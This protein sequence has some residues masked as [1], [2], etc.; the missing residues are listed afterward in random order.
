M[1][2]QIARSLVR[3]SIAGLLATG[4]VRAT[5]MDQTAAAAAGHFAAAAHA[6]GLAASAADP[7]PFIQVAKTLILQPGQTGE[8]VATGF[9]PNGSIVKVTSSALSVVKESLTGNQYRAT[10]SASPNA[11]PLSAG[12]EVRTGN[13]V[14]RADHAVSI[15]GRFKGELTAA[16]GWK[17]RL[18]P[19]T[20]E[21]MSTDA[22]QFTAD[23]FK[24][25][26]PAPFKSVKASLN[27]SGATPENPRYTLQLDSSDSTLLGG[28]D[29]AKVSEELVA[30][31]QDLVKATS[32]AAQAKVQ[33]RMEKVQAK[34]DACAE[35]QAKATEAMLSDLAAYSK[36]A[37]AEQAA[38]GCSSAE[39]TI[40]ADGAVQ[41]RMRCGKD[42]G[43]QA[44]TGSLQRVMGK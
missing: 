6:A 21:G 15:G 18:T 13:R 2:L 3:L 4:L 41:G 31:M 24:S 16:N 26:E 17:I 11:L 12:L 19:V 8:I 29:C 27:T 1:S 7:T 33:A 39:V 14:T 10:V 36:K 5:D 23:F 43:E 32:E 42:V 38:F 30:V 22:I 25:G 44:I 34:A 28:D 40:G 20:R 37:E 35:K 9:F